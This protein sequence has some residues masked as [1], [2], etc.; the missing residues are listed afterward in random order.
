MLLR[1]RLAGRPGDWEEGSPEDLILTLE[2]S[3]SLAVAVLHQVS[4]RVRTKCEPATV[5][6]RVSCTQML[7]L[8]VQALENSPSFSSATVVVGPVSRT[9]CV[10]EAVVQALQHSGVSLLAPVVFGN[11]KG[12]ESISAELGA[13]LGALFPVK[14]SDS[15]TNCELVSLVLA[16]L[17]AVGS[18]F[19]ASVVADAVHSSLWEKVF[20]FFH[21]CSNQIFRSLPCY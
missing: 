17:F 13:T 7:A 3:A 20:P 6:L 21:H 16:V 2:Q 18:H 10:S 12:T 4:S 11:M 5:S 9:R 19:D 14:P 8:A 1:P 15:P